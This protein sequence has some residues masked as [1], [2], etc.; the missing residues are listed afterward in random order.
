MLSI[1]ALRTRVRNSRPYPCASL[2]A[3]EEAELQNRGV[4]QAPLIGR[5]AEEHAEAGHGAGELEVLG[6]VGVIQPLSTTPCSIRWLV[7]P[8]AAC[9]GA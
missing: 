9:S 5:V 3:A 2:L 6:G 8:W 1:C 4:G 7:S